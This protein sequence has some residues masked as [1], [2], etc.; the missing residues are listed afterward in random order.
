MTIKIDEE[1][2][3]LIP[4]ISDTDFVPSKIVVQAILDTFENV[5][6]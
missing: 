4:P 5:G 1:F 2:K 3:S 6:A